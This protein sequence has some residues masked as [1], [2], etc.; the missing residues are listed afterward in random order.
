MSGVLAWHAKMGLIKKAKAQIKLTI[1]IFD[2][3]NFL[4]LLFCKLDVSLS[5]WG[6]MHISIARQTSVYLWSSHLWTN[7]LW[8]FKFGH[9]KLGRILPK[10]PYTQLNFENWCSWEVLD[11]PYARHHNPRFVYFGS[12]LKQ[13]QVQKKDSSFGVPPLNWETMSFM[14]GA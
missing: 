4:H 10:N 9:T 5:I 14:E 1:S 11:L 13:W 6:V 8:S 3:H 12:N 2:E 7:R